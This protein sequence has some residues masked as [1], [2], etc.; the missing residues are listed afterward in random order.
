M[1]DIHSGGVMMNCI[2][3]RNLTKK[4][5]TFTLDNVSFDIPKGYI[6]GFIGENGAGKTTTI[7]SMLNVVK[8]DGGDIKILGKDIDEDEI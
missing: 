8:R 4:Y 1:Y 3:I 6:M 7:K 5:E 2:E